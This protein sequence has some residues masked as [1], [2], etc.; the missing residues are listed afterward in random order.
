VVH[1]QLVKGAAFLF[2]H[3]GW[4]EE[5]PRSVVWRRTVELHQAECEF[6]EVDPHPCNWLEGRLEKRQPVR[7]LGGHTTSLQPPCATDNRRL[8]TRRICRGWPCKVPPDLSLNNAR[9]VCHTPAARIVKRASPVLSQELAQSDLLAGPDGGADQVG[10]R[11]DNDVQLTR[12]D[13]ATIVGVSIATIRRLEGKELHPQRSAEGVYL[14]DPREVEVVRAR[15]SPPPVPRH[16]RDEG[17]LAAEAFT[18]LR[19]GV[20]V[21]DV[22]IALRR[23]ATEIAALYAEWERMGGTLVI[24]PALHAQLA[25][26][27]RHRLL[28][29]G[30]LEA[31]EENDALSLR[32]LVSKA[33]QAQARRQE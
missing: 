20:D 15:R 25:R 31:I 4:V 26:M 8:K 18:L 10:S 13:V 27:V 17:E 9:Q 1:R 21:R 16:C 19:D 24:S 32:D 22:V 2:A 12:G 28:A 29:G 33:I 5:W 14:F 23:P 6:T 11:A 7:R 30:I 3:G